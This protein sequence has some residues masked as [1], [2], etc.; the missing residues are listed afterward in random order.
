MPI[1]GEGE[2]GAHVQQIATHRR[3]DLAE[4]GPDDAAVG[5]P[6]HRLEPA[7]AVHQSGHQ[8]RRDVLQRRP[9]VSFRTANIGHSAIR[10]TLA[11]GTRSV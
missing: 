11:E 2:D 8:L 10:R 7:L 1:L 6:S 5:Q 4:R 9:M 3:L